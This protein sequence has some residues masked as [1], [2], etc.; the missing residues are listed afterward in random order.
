MESA[1]RS[2]THSHY[3]RRLAD[4]VLGGHNNWSNTRDLWFGRRFGHPV[5]GES[6]G[7]LTAVVATLGARKEHTEFLIT[8][9]AM[10]LAGTWW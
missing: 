4:T 8:P 10:R 3:T 7:L 6:S 5:A 1:A 2:L 9:L